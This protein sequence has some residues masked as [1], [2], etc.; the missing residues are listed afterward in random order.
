MWISFNLEIMSA[1][2]V[3]ELLI[4][5]RTAVYS[6]YCLNIERITFVMSL[7]LFRRKC[8]FFIVRCGTKEMSVDTEFVSSG[9]S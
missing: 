3:A 9:V 2:L 8:L 4:V 1:V 6:A 5:D 7:V